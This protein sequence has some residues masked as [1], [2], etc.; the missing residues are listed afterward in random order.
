MIDVDDLDEAYVAEQLKTV[1][2]TQ[3][4]DLVAITTL[5]YDDEVITEIQV[6]RRT[7]ILL[8]E[9]ILRLNHV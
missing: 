3:V 1:R 2:I 7:A 8:A 6:S 4:G 9:D 5:D